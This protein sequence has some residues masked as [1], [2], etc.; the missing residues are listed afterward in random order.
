MYVSHPCVLL[1]YRRIRADLE[2]QLVSEEVGR[3][4]AQLVEERVSAV[5][6]SEGV[7]R[8]LAGR[9]ERERTAIGEQVGSGVGGRILE[10][11]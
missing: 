10:G 4:V 7:R 8:E 5:M 3:R 11:M 6:Q 2:G 9:L 1:P